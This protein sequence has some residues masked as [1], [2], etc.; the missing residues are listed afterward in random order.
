MW[1]SASARGTVH[2]SFSAALERAGKG[3]LLLKLAEGVRS[4][5]DRDGSVV[6]DINHGQ[7]FTLNIVGSKILEMLERGCSQAQIVENISEKFRIRRDI[8][9]RDVCEFLE[10]L[11][12]HRLVESHPPSGGG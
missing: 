11:E 12:K 9:Q 6:L 10:C 8:V 3:N 4:T 2:L 5:H 7:M 1:I